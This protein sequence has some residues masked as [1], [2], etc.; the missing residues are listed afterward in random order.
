LEGRSNFTGILQ[1]VQ[2]GNVI[3]LVDKIEYSL[4]FEDIDKTHIVSD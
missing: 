3:I 4:S 2:D 1:D